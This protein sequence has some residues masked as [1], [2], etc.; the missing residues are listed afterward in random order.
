M[1]RYIEIDGHKVEVESCEDC[2]LRELQMDSCYNYLIRIVCRHP[3]NDGEEIDAWGPSSD[4]PLRE[5]K[6]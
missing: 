4:C 1:M 5:V 6:E 3:D 2:P